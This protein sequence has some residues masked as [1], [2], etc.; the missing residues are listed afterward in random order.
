LNVAIP[1]FLLCSPP[2]WPTLLESS[3]ESRR[4]STTLRKSD[5]SS[6]FFNSNSIRYFSLASNFICSALTLKPP[7]QSCRLGV[8]L[9]LRRTHQHCTA[10]SSLLP[11][12]LS[13]PHSASIDDGSSKRCTTTHDTHPIPPSSHIQRYLSNF[14]VQFHFPRLPPLRAHIPTPL[15]PL[16]LHLRLLLLLYLSAIQINQRCE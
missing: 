9:H 12:L 4:I 1:F 7:T 10:S 5:E 2:I 6:N 8:Y 14:H 16:P 13:P 3:K 11:F 15:P